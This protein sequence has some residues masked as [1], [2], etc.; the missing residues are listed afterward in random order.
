MSDV[1]NAGAPDYTELLD[2]DTL[3]RLHRLG[4][5]ARQP[6]EGFISGVHESPHK[7]FSVEFAEHR[8]YVPGDDLRYLDW[9]VYAKTDRYYVKQY[10]AETNLRATVLVDGSGSMAYTGEEAHEREGRRLSKFE[11]A[12]RVAASL[13]HLLVHQ[14]DA[15]GLATFDTE[16][17]RYIPAR[18][19]PSHLQVILEELQ[20][21]EPGEETALAPIFHDIAERVHRRGL[22]IILS[23]LFDEPEDIVNA[24]HHFRYEKHEVVVFHVLAREEVTFPFERESIFRDLEL[25][26]RRVQVEAAAVRAEYLRRMREFIRTLRRECGKMRVDYVPFSTRYDPAEAMA[27]YLG[28]R[29]RE[30]R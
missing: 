30:A 10:V 14:Q 27:G 28:R 13:A 11:Y 15:V 23:D 21:T 16:V 12:R 19:R 17:R 7:G 4:F 8:P 5:V 24:L 9:H 26:D 20:A 3:A 29:R 6:V 25:R 22:I 1:E 2:A 18:A